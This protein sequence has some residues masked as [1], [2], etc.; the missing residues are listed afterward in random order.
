MTSAHYFVDISQN[1]LKLWMK[2]FVSETRHPGFQ[3]E[4]KNETILIKIK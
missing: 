1:I 2:F 3:F 4:H